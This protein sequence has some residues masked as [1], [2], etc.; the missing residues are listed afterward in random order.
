[1]QRIVFRLGLFESEALRA[2]SEHAHA[3]LVYALVD[4]DVAYLAAHSGTPSLA[5]ARIEHSA[6][7]PK[8][9]EDEWLGIEEI[10]ARRAADPV[11]IACWRCAERIANGETVR[12]Y[13][14]WYGKGEERRYQV[15]VVDREGRGEDPTK[16]FVVP[17][18]RD[19]LRAPTSKIALRVRLFRGEKERAYSEF[20]L[21][22]FLAAL[23]TANFVY[24]KHTT[25][26]ALYSASV[27]YRAERFPR[28]EWKGIAAVVADGFG[29]CEDLATYRSAELL[30]HS[31]GAHPTFRWRRLGRLSVYHIVVRHA[32]GSIEDPSLLLGM[33]RGGASLAELTGDA[34]N[35]AN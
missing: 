23:T 24:L 34:A 16:F 4:A 21:S 3:I 20:V 18:L 28:E 29:D 19:R 6:R 10:L 11:S 32:D 5:D 26:P 33:G 2:Y 9:D 12:P 13:V 14:R 17:R 30:A 22:R 8:G 31:A 7:A 1:V 15:L 27:C 35:A 25:A